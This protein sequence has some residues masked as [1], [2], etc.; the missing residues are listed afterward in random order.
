MTTVLVLFLSLLFIMC[1]SIY[2]WWFQ[3]EK[4]KRLLDQE[5]EGL[6]PFNS[7]MAWGTYSIISLIIILG[8]ITY[9]IFDLI[10]KIMSV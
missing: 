7:P 1:F 5:K 6:N 4:Y 9:I 8:I 10:K 2:N 3:R